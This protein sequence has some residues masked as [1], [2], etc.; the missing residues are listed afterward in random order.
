MATKV[1]KSDTEPTNTNGKAPKQRKTSTKL[2]LK[3][4][5]KNS[6]ASTKNVLSRKEKL[7]AVRK[8]NQA[9]MKA[10]ELMSQRNGNATDAQSDI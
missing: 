9:L 2:N 1:T 4:N 6:K 5:N 8:A 7:E 3:T 10:L